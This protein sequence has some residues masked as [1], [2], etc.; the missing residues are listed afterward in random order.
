MYCLALD[1]DTEECS[2][3]L[4]KIQEKRNQNNQ[5]FQW[6]SAEARDNERNI[7]IVTHGG[8]KTGSDVVRQDPSQNQRV[9][10]N[11]EPRKQFDAPKQDETFKEARQEF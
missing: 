8:T 4:V 5:I 10:K 11:T 2:T 7:N 3:L 6:I 1:H 9:K